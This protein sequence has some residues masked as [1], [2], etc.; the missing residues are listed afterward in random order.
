MKIR[1][2]FCPRVMLLLDIDFGR[3]VLCRELLAV[4]LTVES[5]LTALNWKSEEE[6]L[7]KNWVG[8][9][10]QMCLISRLTAISRYRAGNEK[11]LS[12]S[13]GAILR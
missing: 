4:M 5:T 8:S 2:P 7:L 13:M 6:L 9:V 1:I 12:D 11:V 3:I 10:R